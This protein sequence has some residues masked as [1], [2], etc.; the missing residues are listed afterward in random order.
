M[1]TPR[2]FTGT[3]ARQLLRRARTGTL[4]T[5]NRD[6][7]IP[8]ASLVNVATDVAGWPLILVSDP[9]L[10]HEEPAG[11]RPRQPDGG[12]TCRRRAMP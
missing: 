4:S 11:R 5:L 3:E 9:R 12:G 1:S 6:D 8:Y 10:A 2:S 7:G